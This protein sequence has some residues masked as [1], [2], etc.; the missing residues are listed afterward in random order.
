MTVDSSDDALSG[1]DTSDSLDAF[2]ADFFN[3]TPKVE[4]PVQEVEEP[5]EPVADEET[6]EAGLETP[7]EPSDADETD[8]VDEEVTP[9]E[10]PKKKT[11]QDRIK[12]L[13]AQ[14]YDAERAANARIAELERKITELAEAKATT[15][16]V[17]VLSDG[18][19]D[20]QAEVEGE[21]LYPLGEFDPKYIRDLT[22][23]TIKQENDAA[24]SY[25]QKAEQEAAVSTA[26]ETQRVAWV[27]K[28][29]E[30]QTEIPDITDKIIGLDEV[31]R[32]IDPSYNQYL[33][34]VIM[35]LDNG[36]RVLAYLSDNPDKAR[37]I[38]SSGAASATVA[39]GRLDG[40][41]AKPPVQAKVVTQ[42]P[43]PASKTTRG[44]SGQFSTRADTDDLDAFEK[45]FFKKK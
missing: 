27:G 41:M 33:T 13:T 18:A 40:K 32:G 15:P 21:L 24:T 20:P 44:T 3:K 43:K 1:F 4:E 26:R 34:D 28:L 6:H 19:P 25:R 37:E 11:A 14:R 2:E 12:E 5:A 10:K 35:S 45:T 42:A 17:G 7:D 9:E 8:E 30:A 22:R 39:L 23:F 38:V 29:E 16:V 36:P 31:T